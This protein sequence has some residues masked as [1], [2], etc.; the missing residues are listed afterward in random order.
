MSNVSGAAAI[1]LD[2]QLDDGAGATGRFRATLGTG[3]TNT[4]PA[5]TALAAPYSEDNVYTVCYRN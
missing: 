2:T 1:A 5:D 4:A 3:G